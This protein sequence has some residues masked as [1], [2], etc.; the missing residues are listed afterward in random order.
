MSESDARVARARPSRGKLV[1]VVIQVA[2]ALL[3]LR[4]LV[5]LLGQVD[6][7]QVWDSVSGLTAVQV[8]VLAVLVVAVRTLNATPYHLL[9]PGLSLR[10][11]VLN[12]LS[13]NLVSTV[14]PPPSD[15]VV[16]YSMFRSWDIDL[17]AA[18][19]GVTLDSILLYVVRFAAP[20]VGLTVVAVAVELTAGMVVA[21][22]LSVLLACVIAGALVLVTRADRLAATVGRRAGM[23]GHRV[24]PESVDPEAWSSRTVAFRASAG[25]TLRLHWRRAM[26]ALVA[27]VLCDA[28]IVVLSVRFS[29]V[30]SDAL[31]PFLIYGAFLMVYPLTLLPFAGL[32]VVTR[33]SSSSRSATPTPRTR[34][35][36]SPRS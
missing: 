29:G 26:L 13:G 7:A 36:S 16:R 25:R 15:M 10:R 27:M 8:A 12:D 24:R 2:L 18:F 28:T 11:A 34:R 21:G 14:A 30:H 5:S 20:L 23:L 22:V 17:S 31:G 35:R 32:G 1:R 9:V 6:W 33:S 3:T 4:I 19:A